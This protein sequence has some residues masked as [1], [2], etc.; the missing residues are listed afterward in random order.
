MKQLF[1]PALTLAW[2]VLSLPASGPGP[3]SPAERY[4]SPTDLAVL[5]GGRYVLTANQTADSVSLVDLE[6]CRVVAEVPCGCKPVAVACSRDGR[7]AAVS[8]LWSGTITLLEVRGETL[9]LAGQVTLGPFPRGLA[10]APDGEGF[11]ATGGEEVVQVRWDSGRVIRRWPAPREPRRIALSVDGGWLAV[12]SSRS[13]V[14]RCWSTDTG[15]LHWERTI[16]D[17]FNLRGLAFTADGNRLVCAHGVRR[18]FPVSKENIEEGWVI[19][20]RLTRLPVSPNAVPSLEQVALDTRGRAV[21][22]PYGV[23][24][25]ANSRWLAVSGSGTHELLI[26]EADSVPW[27]GGDPGDVLDPR[28]AASKGNLR[29]IPL[30]G[31]PLSITFLDKGPNLVVANYLLDAVQVVDAAAGKVLRTIPLGAPVQLSLARKGEILFYDAQRSHEQWFSC[32]TCHVEGHT[33]D[34]TFDTLNDDSYGNPKLTPTLRNVTK[35][36]PWTWHGW[37][38]DL[39]AAVEKSLT[40]TMFGPKPSADDIKA[41]LAFLET[42]NHPPNPNRGPGGSLSAAARR[43]QALFQG[44]ANCSRCHQ[45][46][47][48]TST[49]TYDVKLEPDGSP[50]LRWNPPSLRGVY[51]RGPYLHDGRAKTLDEVLR[52]FHNPEKLGASPLSPGERQ[53]LIEF[54]MSL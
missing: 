3:T 2:F 52:T 5:P 34:L 6:K 30:G 28:L 43:G 32:N 24:F 25:S 23:A 16:E 17:G 46:E 48:Y 38:K 45:G 20:S 35:T 10:F 44:K 8:N 51:D 21:G 47:D 36:G 39:G 4:R 19:D 27:S 26:L 50:Y 12:A 33:C 29:R 15:R 13:G 31:R 42:L 22:D 41:M 9:K 54:L 11:Y 18:S 53:A 7:R 49:H 14:V 37:Q 40:Q 1:A